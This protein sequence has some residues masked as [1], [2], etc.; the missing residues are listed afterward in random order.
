MAGPVGRGRHHRDVAGVSQQSVEETIEPV[1]SKRPSLIEAIDQM[2]IVVETVET[3]EVHVV[4]REHLA[5]M[6]SS[7]ELRQD[8]SD[9]LGRRLR[10]RLIGAPREVQGE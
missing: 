4:G 7:I 3:C 5:P 2:E 8:V 1:V 10:G 9:K 6:H